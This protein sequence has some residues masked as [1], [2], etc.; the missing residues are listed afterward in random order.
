[1]PPNTFEDCE[2]E[3]TAQGNV[4]AKWRERSA[5]ALAPLDPKDLN[6]SLGLLQAS[7]VDR[8]TLRHIGEE[9][10]AKIFSDPLGKMLWK[11]IGEAQAGGSGIHFR[12]ALEGAE[13]ARLPWELL[14]HRDLGYLSIGESFTLSRRVSTSRAV[15]PSRSFRL[16][17]SILVVVSQ[18][19]DREQ[20]DVDREIEHIKSALDIWIRQGLVQVELERKPTIERLRELA[21]S[22]P[23]QIFH[24][25]GHGDAGRIILVGDFGRE[26][27]VE[28]ARFADLVC[29]DSLV[30][31]LK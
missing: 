27:G 3:V 22:T 5:K 9:L 28:A 7:S 10:F 20:L 24:Y 30:L 29:T 15:E 31:A 23:Y 1:M 26:E 6:W 4:S 14:Y 16:P 12:L 19:Q 21:K 2:I 11:A 13:W 17:I 18:P 25:I 8:D